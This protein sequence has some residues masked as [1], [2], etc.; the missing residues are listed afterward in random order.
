MERRIEHMIDL[1]VQAVNK[2]LDAFKLRVLEQPSP[3]TDISYFQTELD[4]LQ[5]DLDTILVPSMD[6]PKFAPTAPTDDTMLD[7]LFDEEISQFKSTHAQG[8]KHGSSHTSYAN[9]D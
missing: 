7:A 1:K 9:K 3:T 5:D 6:A 8:K 4:H 2:R